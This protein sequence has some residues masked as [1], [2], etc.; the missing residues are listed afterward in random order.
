MDDAHLPISD[1]NALEFLKS[2]EVL[3]CIICL[4][5]YGGVHPPITLPN[6]HHLFHYHCIERWISTANNTHNQCPTCRAVMFEDEDLP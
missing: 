1:A 3:Q 4:E 6:C 5:Q 2:L